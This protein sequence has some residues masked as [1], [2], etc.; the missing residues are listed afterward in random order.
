[1]KHFI[2]LI[3]CAFVIIKPVIVINAQDNKTPEMKENNL[4]ISLPGPELYTQVEEN[5]KILVDYILLLQ[6]YF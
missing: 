3:I 2:F 4:D 5:N 1:M 6:G